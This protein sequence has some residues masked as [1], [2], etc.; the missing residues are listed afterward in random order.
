MGVRRDEP[1]VNFF[2]YF[3]SLMILSKYTVPFWIEF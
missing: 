1:K 3:K 2:F